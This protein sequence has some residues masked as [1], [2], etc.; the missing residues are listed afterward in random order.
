MPKT[1]FLNSRFA[2]EMLVTVG[3]LT[4]YFAI[5]R[6]QLP[7]FNTDKLVVS[8]FLGLVG[9]DREISGMFSIFSLGIMPFISAYLIVELGSVI[10]PFLKKYRRGV[11]GAGGF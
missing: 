3:L 2:G 7:F 1:K 10:I 8:E 5:S 4:L 6:I 11:I 9:G